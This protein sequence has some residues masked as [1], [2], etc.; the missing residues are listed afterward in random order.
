VEFYNIQKK[1][2]AIEGDFVTI[3]LNYQLYQLQMVDVQ[4]SEVDA[5]RSPLKVGA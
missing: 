1:G 5:K 3:I 4:A 2:H